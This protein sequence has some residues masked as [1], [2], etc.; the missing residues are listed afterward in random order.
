[1]N[2]STPRSLFPLVLAGAVVLGATTHA[3]IG[4]LIKKKLPKLVAPAEPQPV[5]KAAPPPKYCGSITDDQLDR[6][7]KAAQAER[8]VLEKQLA[9]RKVQTAAA[10]AGKRR[11]EQFTPEGMAR[12]ADCREAAIAKDPRTKERER[13]SAL[14]DAAIRKSDAPSYR[15]YSAEADAL[16]EQIEADA[17]KSCGGGLKAMMAPSA[18]EAEANRAAVAAMNATYE[19]STEAALKAGGFDAEEYAKLKECVLGR[20]QTPKTTPT[21]PESEQI[22]DARSD[23]LRKALG[24]K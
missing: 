15:K 2:W 4:G 9:V 17:D 11:A 19:D 16:S 10:E 20:L 8:A 3:Q 5:A 21:S 22:I 14:A 23:D 12:S 7:L 13:L 24:V 1:M 18:E 6:L